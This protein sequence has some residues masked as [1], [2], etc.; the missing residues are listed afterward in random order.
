FG[1]CRASR[2]PRTCCSFTLTAA[3]SPWPR[4]PVFLQ[5]QKE[6]KMRTSILRGFIPTA[7]APMFENAEGEITQLAGDVDEVPGCS[8]SLAL[9]FHGERLSA[10]VTPVRAGDT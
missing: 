2:P 9:D 7:K 5:P 1:S 6:Q 10:S 4:R 3:A 8:E